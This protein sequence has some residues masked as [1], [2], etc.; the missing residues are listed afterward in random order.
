MIR[1]NSDGPSGSLVITNCGVSCP[2]KSSSGNW[3]MPHG[4]G[5]PCVVSPD[6]IAPSPHPPPP[7]PPVSQDGVHDLQPH[8]GSHVLRHSAR[9]PSGQVVLVVPQPPTGQQE[10]GQAWQKPVFGSQVLLQVT[11][12]PF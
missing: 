10:R 5:E 11:V 8:C 3:A 1:H 12:V 9:W 2:V 4:W 7:P 6:P